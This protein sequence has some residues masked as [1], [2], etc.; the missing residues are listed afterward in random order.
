MLDFPGGGL[1]AILGVGCPPFRWVC[2]A[3]G[4]DVAS[5]AG[6]PRS[7]RREP[8]LF[9]HVSLSTLV[10]S[11]PGRRGGLVSHLPGKAP[12]VPRLVGASL[13]SGAPSCAFAMC[14]GS[15]GRTSPCLGIF[16]RDWTIGLPVP[17]QGCLAMLGVGIVA[18]CIGCVCVCV[19]GFWSVVWTVVLPLPSQAEPFA[20]LGAVATHPDGH[21]RGAHCV[22]R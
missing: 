7:A 12:L 5:L 2:S 8:S 22:H 10:F 15:G 1:I 18:R 11:W 21:H 9:A 4:R 3:L 16:R 6:M 19:W 20:L 13:T 14:L 17:S